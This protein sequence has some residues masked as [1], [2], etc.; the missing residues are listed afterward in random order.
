MIESEHTGP[1]AAVRL[2]G[3]RKRFGYREA[4]RGVDFEVPAGSSV[5]IFGANGAGKSTLL[6]IVAT[7][8]APSAGGGEVLGFDLRRQALEIRRR[9]GVIF[10]Q[11]FLRSEFTLEENL[12]LYGELYGLPT[13][14]RA[15]ELLER[16]GLAHRRKDR[17]ET[18]SQGM[19]KRADIARSL[20]HDP[21]LWLLDEP[22]SGLDPEGRSLLEG[23]ILDFTATGGTVVLVTHDVA[24]GTRLA[25]RTLTIHDGVVARVADAKNQKREGQ[26]REYGSV[27]SGPATQN[28]G[29]EQ[30]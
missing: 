22:F 20:L 11:S 5:A 13:A 1:P 6:R 28:G 15:F 21:Q 14:D 8:W 12:R 30:R 16:L 24:S 2:R 25:D 26:R 7:R 10:H 23:M 9:V 19:V 29:D 17:V 3:I 27:G 4:L 18:Y